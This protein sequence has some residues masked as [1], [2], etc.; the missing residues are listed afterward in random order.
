MEAFLLFLR[1]LLIFLPKDFSCFLVDPDLSASAL[2]SAVVSSQ[3]K[4]PV[5]TPVVPAAT[6]TGSINGGGRRPLTL[7]SRGVSFI[8]GVVRRDFGGRLGVTAAGGVTVAVGGG[9]AAGGGKRGKNAGGLGGV[10]GSVVSEENMKDVAGRRSSDA[11]LI[12]R[13]LSR[14]SVPKGEPLCWKRLSDVPLS[15]VMVVRAG[16]VTLCAEGLIKLWARPSIPPPLPPMPPRSV[17][18]PQLLPLTTSQVG[19][20]CSS[21]SSCGLCST[22]RGNVKIYGRYSH[23]CLWY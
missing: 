21:C 5:A 17:D 22:R 4:A 8:G 18:L 10:V 14:Q 3:D 16:V 11:G 23:R 12:S 13:G 6:S 20:S 2:T 19:S 7:P 1:G 9:G 15:Q